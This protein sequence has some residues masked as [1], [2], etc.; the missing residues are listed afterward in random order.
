MKLTEEEKNLH[1]IAQMVVM[2]PFL[3]PEG[4]MSKDEAKKILSRLAM[5][6][7]EEASEKI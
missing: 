2:N 3:P 5:K 4:A 1:K 7:L 6:E